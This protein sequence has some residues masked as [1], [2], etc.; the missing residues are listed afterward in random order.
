MIDAAAVPVTSGRP[1]ED[2]YATCTI[3]HDGYDYTFRF[4]KGFASRVVFNAP[5]GT[6]IPVYQQT[7]VF[8][9]QD[10]HGPLPNTTLS[11]TG[12]P[13]A[14][15]VEVEIQDG[16]IVPPD[17]LGPIEEIQIGF[18]KR[19]GPPVPPNPRVIPR[20]GADEI[21]RI[22]VRERGKN[23]GGVHAFQSDDDGSVDVTNRAATCPPAC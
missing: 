7:G 10:T 1:N 17:Y 12:G 18:K 14:L 3:Q 5:D 20:R 4:Y 8:N 22:N 2:P 15:D 16:P 13:L 19:G 9:C 6:Q 21:S 11:V 23:N